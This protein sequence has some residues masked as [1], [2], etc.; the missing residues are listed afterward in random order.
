MS[1]QFDTT[2]KHFRNYDFKVT[3]CKEMSNDKGIKVGVVRGYASTFGN[4]DRFDDVIVEGAFTE[5]IKNFKDR[6][7]MIR[8]LWMHQSDEIIGGYPADKAYEDKKGLFV[9]GHINLDTIRGS[10]AYALAKQGVMVDFSIGFRIIEATIDKFDGEEIRMITALELFEISLVGEPMN[11]EAQITQVKA[12]SIN[13]KGLPIAPHDTEWNA[14]D[15]YGRCLK[16]LGT[17]DAVSYVA[18]AINKTPEE[19][20]SNYCLLDVK[21]GK[22]TIIPSAVL[23]SAA[24]LYVQADKLDISKS[25]VVSAKDK[26]D[27]FYKKMGMDSPFL[28]EN[29]FRIDD[30]DVLSERTLEKVLK[31]GVLLRGNTA[32]AVVSALKKSYKREVDGTNNLLQDDKELIAMNKIHNLFRKKD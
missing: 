4:I 12:S 18:M 22:L 9:E 2:K 26:L 27:G 16:L 13:A 32:K 5:T 7:R 25:D 17:E 30:L 15:A 29:L 23:E 10:E 24:N 6:D 8:M 3:E 21:E 14:S 11:P 1:T 20:K 19:T 28:E 31:K